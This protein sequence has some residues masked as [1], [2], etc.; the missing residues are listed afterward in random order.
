MKNSLTICQTVVAQA[1]HPVRRLHPS[2]VIYHYMDD[3][4][5]ATVSETELQ[6]VVTALTNAVQEA[7]LQVAPEKIQRSQPWTYLGWRITLQ[8]I[9]SQ[10]L[11]IRLVIKG[12]GRLQ[13][14]N[15]QDPAIIYVPANKDNLDWLL[16]EDTGFQAA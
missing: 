10:P 15:G 16:A 12:R 8:E 7:G 14:L 5:I 2:T 13:E 3:I 6:T 9:S 4:L 1:I 11:Q